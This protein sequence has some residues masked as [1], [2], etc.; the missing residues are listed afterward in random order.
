MIRRFINTYWTT[1]AVALLVL[2]CSKLSSVDNGSQGS[3][4][5][6][7]PAVSPAEIQ[8][9]YPHTVEFKST[10]LHGQK[11]T[12]NG[13]TCRTCHGKDLSGAATKV[14]CVSCHEIF[15]HSEDFKTKTHGSLFLKNRET[16]TRCHGADSRGGSIG[17]SCTS[18]HNYPHDPKWALPKNHGTQF[19]A[20]IGSASPTP[21]HP[22]VGCQT[23]HTQAQAEGGKS[24]GSNRVGCDSCH[25]MVPHGDDFNNGGHATVAGTHEGGCLNCHTGYTRLMGPDYTSCNDCHSGMVLQPMTWVTPSPMPSSSASRLPASKAIRPMSVHPRPF[26]DTI[27]R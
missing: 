14:S 3:S 26:I 13:A 6:A 2:S 11:Y 7:D 20:E 16:C 22:W 23:C 5:P 1:F 4:T 18:C 25:V 9:I 15:P 21:N 24:D 10:R 27:K 19:V 8:A 12:A 17:I